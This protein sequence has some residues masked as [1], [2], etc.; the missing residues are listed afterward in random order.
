[1]VGTRPGE[2]PAK[3]GAGAERGF[4]V[5]QAGFAV[6]GRALLHPLS[7]DLARGQ[8]YGLIGHNG[9][10]KSTFLKLLARQER[11][12]G[13]EIRFDGVPLP[14]WGARALAQRVSYLPQTL[15]SGTGLSVREIVAFG[16]YPWHGPLGRLG[17]QDRERIGAALQLAGLADF[18]ERRIDT[19]SGGERQRAWI[20]MLIAQDSDFLLLDEPISA[21]DLAQQVE[22]LRLLHGL[23]RERGVGIVAVL[24]DIN[25]ASRFC[26]RLIALRGGRL[27][28]QGDPAEIMREDVL[29]GLY[30]VP[31][32]VIVHP[33][34][35][36]LVGFPR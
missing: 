13:G 7:L 17:A 9:S 11:P 28:R 25:M 35:G 15:P 30:D 5:V 19:L 10:G 27:S 34:T 6:E 14:E 12:T 21:L 22:V 36:G 1:M 24:H 20:A 26:D 2:A 16:R 31:M 4:D 33:E 18:A 23:T 32:S 8:F 29:A 3:A